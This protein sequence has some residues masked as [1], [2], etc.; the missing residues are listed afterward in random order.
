MAYP[1]QELYNA[2]AY[3]KASP[4]SHLFNELIVHLHL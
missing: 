1:A 3:L 4:T 2:L